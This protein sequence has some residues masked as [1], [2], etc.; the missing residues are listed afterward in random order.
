MDGEV[1]GGCPAVDMAAWGMGAEWGLVGD[2]VGDDM[3]GADGSGSV[4][5]EY[6]IYC[7]DEKVLSILIALMRKRG[8]V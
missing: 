3:E 8:V 7:I 2:L 6:A 4:S 1:I 5:V